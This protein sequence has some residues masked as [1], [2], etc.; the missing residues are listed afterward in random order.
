M[1]WL[2]LQSLHMTCG[3]DAFVKV[4]V[5]K[6]Q[7]RSFGISCAFERWAD[8]CPLSQGFWTDVRGYYSA[9]PNLVTVDHMAGNRSEVSQLMK[10]L[11]SAAYV[12]LPSVARPTVVDSLPL[13]QTLHLPSGPPSLPRNIHRPSPSLLLPQTHHSNPSNLQCIPLTPYR[14]RIRSSNCRT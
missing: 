13:T 1:C 9:P 7:V 6:A 12:T 10:I 14:E 11:L 2:R 5:I 8:F 3:D 4:Y